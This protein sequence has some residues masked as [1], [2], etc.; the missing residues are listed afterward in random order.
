MYKLSM[1][2]LYFQKGYIYNSLSGGIYKFNDETLEYLKNIETNDNAENN[3]FFKAIKDKGYIVETEKNEFEELNNRRKHMLFDD[4]SDIASFVI[5]VTTRCNYRCIYCFE[6]GIEQIDMSFE[7]ERDVAFF[8]K[9]R[10]KKN[11]QLKNMYITWFGG[12]PLLCK[13]VI[14]ELG[15]ELIT[16]C[17]QNNIGFKSG[18]ITN[19]YFLD[20]N[21]Y[22]ML[23]RFNI[24]YIQITLDGDAEWYAYYKNPKDPA[25]YDRVIDN[26]I[27]ISNYQ[28]IHIRFNCTK[29][30]VLSIKNVIGK[31]FTNCD[32]N[33][34]HIHFSLDRVFSADNSIQLTEK[35]FLVFK[36]EILDL[37]LD[38][39]WYRMIFK[40]IPAS[41]IAPCGLMRKNS[42]AIDSKGN[43]YKC[44]HYIGNSKFS[45]G[46]AKNG[47]YIDQRS[48]DFLNTPLPSGCKDCKVFPVC[49]GGCTQKRHE[50]IV[51]FTCDEKMK[52]VYG[53]I[54]RVIKA[55]EL[56]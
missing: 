12:E 3:I 24:E 40:F 52:E 2:N 10:F 21:N 27:K 11:K 22:E 19:G 39:G 36:F 16:F 46:D 35:E 7:T 44:E 30:N 49:R 5:S 20:E 26:I 8:I 1:Y 25:S 29:N 55:Y 14:V 41:K 47:E 50:N 32:I 13:N 31:L 17:N 34:E 53:V 23:R 4:T 54:E 18:I 45:V 48:L 38:L 28:D 56:A 33:K 9:E 6:K 15:K 51:S 43:L 42:F 37:F